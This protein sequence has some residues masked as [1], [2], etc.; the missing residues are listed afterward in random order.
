[1]IDGS[2]QFGEIDTGTLMLTLRRMA[3]LEL[4]LG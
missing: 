3:N 4:E 2:N 1:M